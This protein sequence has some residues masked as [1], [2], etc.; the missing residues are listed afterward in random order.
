MPASDF[1]EAD[2]QAALRR[3]GLDKL[4]AGD[5]HF[6]RGVYA[7]LSVPL[8]LPPGFSIT[9]PPATPGLVDLDVEPEA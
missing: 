4:L 2:F 6:L 8:E 5:E 1:P 9:L 7:R 3:A